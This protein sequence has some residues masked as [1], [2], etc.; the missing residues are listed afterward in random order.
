M[1]E[2]PT[3][4]LI[5]VSGPPGSGKSTLARAIG[6]ALPCPVIGRDE[7]KEGMVHA[8]GGAFETAPD[9]PLTRRTFPLFFDVLELLLRGGV[10][11]VAD[12]A[13]QD[14]RWRVGLEPLTGLAHLRV[15][16]CHT[17]GAIGLE[18]AAA[19]SEARLGV[20]RHEA[21]GQASDLQ[22]EEWRQFYADFERVSLPAPSLDVDT[23]AGYEPALDKIVAF[24]RTAG[25]PGDPR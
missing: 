24:C 8:L 16:Q 20:S 1:T 15:V 25:D 11:V 19:R 9:D 10:T 6:D 14:A 13:F 4:T 7:I 17:D 5:V 22:A 23:T 3:P 21:P 12:A 18:R 2:V